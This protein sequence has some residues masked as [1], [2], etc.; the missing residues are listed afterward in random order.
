MCEFDYYDRPEIWNQ[1]LVKARKPHK[2]NC[3]GV[4]ISPG[5]IYLKHFSVFDG[6]AYA[7]KMCD[8]CHTLMCEF[9]EAHEGFTWCPS[10]FPYSLNECISENDDDSPR[11]KEML[12]EITQ[13]R[14]N[15]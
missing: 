11:W 2:C 9:S 12:K 15:K 3:C 10:D 5:E 4:N 1:K 8:P 14:V 6:Q 7:E 13:R